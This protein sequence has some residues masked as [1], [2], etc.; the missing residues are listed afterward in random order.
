[1]TEAFDQVAKDTDSR[2]R[3]NPGTAG[4]VSAGKLLNLSGPQFLRL[5]NGYNE[6]TSLRRLLQ[7]ILN[8]R[9]IIQ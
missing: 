6:S 5:Y 4:C 3:M 8:I 7:E 1:M 2:A 9:G